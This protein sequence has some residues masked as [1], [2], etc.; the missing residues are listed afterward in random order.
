M[1]LD[2]PLAALEGDV[3]P[4]AWSPDGKRILLHHFAAAIEQLY[5]FDLSDESL[6]KLAHPA[7]SFLYA[8]GVLAPPAY[9]T[10]EG[11][12]FAHWNNATSPF[13]II[14]LDGNQGFF[15]RKV[16][17]A[18]AVPRSHHWKSV[19]YRTADQQKIQAWLS[20][21]AAAEKGPFPTIIHMH[22]GPHS[23]MPE[24]YTPGAQAW[25]DHGFAFC[26][27]NYRGSSTF[28]RDFLEQIWGRLGER[29]VEDLVAARSYLIERGTARPDAIF[30]TGWSYGGYLTLLA[31]GKH[32][33]LWAGGLAGIAIADWT[34]NYELSNDT[35][36]AFQVELFGGKPAELAEQ[37]ARSSPIS[38]VDNINAPILIIQGRNDSRTPAK[39]IEIF[40]ARLK[41]LGKAIK[42]HW[43]E[44]GHIG[45]GVQ[46]GIEHNQ[47]ML[48]FAYN[49][50][51]SQLDDI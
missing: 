37:Y 40:E 43:F 47:L 33:D 49:V 26:S 15:K 6:I 22:G 31:L 13:H 8:G 27:V 39:S 25:V 32:P 35:L 23:V 7:G 29:E 12:I 11:E 1:Q 42:V 2:I 36:R 17:S 3:R 30:L 14:A 9:F 50:L 34:L 51:N 5:T 38:Y 16:I 48:E 41:E 18:G 10:R 28:G 19:S 46:E 20:L 4:L 44:T 24:A 21:P 45:G